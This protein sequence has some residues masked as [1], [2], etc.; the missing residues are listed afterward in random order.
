MRVSSSSSFGSLDGTM[1]VVPVTQAHLDGNL[2]GASGIFRE[3][4]GLVGGGLLDHLRET[5][6]RFD[7][8]GSDPY[9]IP[10]MTNNRMVLVAPY[11]PGHSLLDTTAAMHALGCTA[12]KGARTMRL[13]KVAVC[14]TVV[15]NGASFLLENLLQGGAFSNFDFGYGDTS[16]RPPGVEEFALLGGG[17]TDRYMDH[18]N[19]GLGFGKSVNL[20]REVIL[21]PPNLLA[22]ERLGE[23]VREWFDGTRVKVTVRDIDWLR[24]NG[25]GGLLA[26]NAGSRRPA[27]MIELT[28]IPEDGGSEDDIIG[29]VGKAVIFD[30]GGINL[31][32]TEG[33]TDM[34]G[35]K[36]GGAAVIGAMMS[37]AKLGAP[38]IVKAFIPVTENMTGGDATRPGDVITML[39]GKTVEVLNTDAEGRL[40]LADAIWYAENQGCQR[41]IDAAT[42]TGSAVFALGHHYGALFTHSEGLHDQIMAASISAGEAFWRMPLDRRYDE[43]LNSPVA[44]MANLAKEPRAGGAITAAHFL[45]RF[46]RSATLAHLDIAG[47]IEKLMAG[48]TRGFAAATMARVAMMQ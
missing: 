38:R 37:I 47:S 19:R 45:H 28:Y 18:M 43:R 4:D 5:P 17:A 6:G 34:K 20:A 32:P 2:G 42:L 10:S 29:L 40:I 9:F 41:I 14:D 24:E 44:N 7:P 27:V 22:P 21:T 12:V 33:I 23:M 8:A 31:K 3:V 15:P 46:V 11:D 26:V 16:K 39:S 36:G 13:R 35:D 1:V 48:K 30:S 25:W